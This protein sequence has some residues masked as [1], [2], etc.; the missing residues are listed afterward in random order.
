M[1]HNIYVHKKT[2][3]PY[4]TQRT[5]TLYIHVIQCGVRHRAKLYVVG[6][7]GTHHPRVEC[8]HHLPSLVPL[9]PPL[10]PLPPSFLRLCIYVHIYVYINSV[11]YVKT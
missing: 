7:K 6:D 10:P 1:E 9:L 4:T 2:K 8:L 11:L 5:G 3:V